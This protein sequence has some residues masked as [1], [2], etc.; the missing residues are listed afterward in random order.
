MGR[1]CREASYIR[2]AT[3]E[4]GLSGGQYPGW[5]GGGWLVLEAREVCG[6]RQG[7]SLPANDVCMKIRLL[8]PFI[9]SRAIGSSF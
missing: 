7:P 6:A 1:S 3:V 5:R 2:E 9:S 4:L 8:G